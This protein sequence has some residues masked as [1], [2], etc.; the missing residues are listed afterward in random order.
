MKYLLICSC[1]GMSRKA[2]MAYDIIKPK[3][4]TPP[5]V[6]GKENIAK[7]GAKYDNTHIRSISK[8]NGNFAYYIDINDNGKITEEY[9]LIKGSKIA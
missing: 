8:L 4:P 5:I 6:R 1:S 7:L 2:E 9:D 3:L